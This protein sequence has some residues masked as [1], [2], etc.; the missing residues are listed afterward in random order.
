MIHPR[1]ARDEE[2]RW[3]MADIHIHSSIGDGMADVHQILKHVEENTNLDV[4][5]ITDHDSLDGSYQARELAAK[6]SYHFQVVTGM[7]VTT[8]EGHLL[9]LYLES[10]VPS[11]KP[12]EKTIAAI[13]SQGGLC[14]VPHPMSWLTH[15]ISKQSLEKIAANSEPGLYLDGIETINAT[16]A[17]LISNPKAKR[18]NHRH[19]LAETGGSDAHFLTAVGS[20]VT[21][22]LG[23]TAEELKRSLLHRIT[24]AV[25]EFK[26]RPC[27]VGVIQLVRQLIKSKGFPVGNILRAI[28][29]RDFP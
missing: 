22:F 24:R 28:R 10:P 19:M 13:H 25:N 11:L 9:A 18:V 1:Q 26:F 15:S 5:A 29:Q 23:R 27:E 16:I 3:G 20:G 21:L 4:I 7:E 14:I 17:G 2:M 6:Y 12:L 8:E